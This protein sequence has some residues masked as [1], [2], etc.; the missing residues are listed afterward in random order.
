M[1]VG[2]CNASIG[3]SV[4]TDATGQNWVVVAGEMYTMP[5]ANEPYPMP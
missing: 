4:D 1:P 5:F 2:V 3:Y